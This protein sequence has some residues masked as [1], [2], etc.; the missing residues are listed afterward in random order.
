M[1]AAKHHHCL[2][3]LPG[4][5]D[6]GWCS[7]ALVM[8]RYR[9]SGNICSRVTKSWSAEE[10][11][12]VASVCLQEILQ[13][14][15]PWGCCQSASRSPCPCRAMRGA[16]LWGSFTRGGNGG[17]A[18]GTG[19]CSREG[20]DFAGREVKCQPGVMS[21]FGAL[22]QPLTPLQLQGSGAREM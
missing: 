14:Q 8:L 2:D 13:P 16:G 21:C 4:T 20:R 9:R 17:A 15:G 11:A 3:H 22:F 18:L 12:L 1:T 10:L 19:R 6:T 5:Q 7:Q